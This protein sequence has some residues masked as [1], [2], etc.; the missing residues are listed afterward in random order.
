MKDEMKDKINGMKQEIKT[1]MS[2][3]K[4]ALEKIIQKIDSK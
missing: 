2:E 4:A 3:M 1:E